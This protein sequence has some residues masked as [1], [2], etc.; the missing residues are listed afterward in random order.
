MGTTAEVLWLCVLGC[1][2][3]TAAEAEIP[4][5]KNSSHFQ[6]GLHQVGKCISGGYECIPHSKPWQVAL[7]YNG[8][9]YCSGVLVHQQWVL[10]A[11]HCWRRSYTVRLGLHRIQQW[12]EPGS[13][14]IEAN[15]SVQHPYYTP[16]WR[17]YDLMLVK[18]SKPVEL[19]ETIQPIHVA[20][21]CPET[22]TVC[23]ISGWGRLLDGQFPETLQCAYIPIV[24]EECCKAV[25]PKSYGDSMFCAGGLDHRDSCPDA[26]EQDELCDRMLIPGPVGTEISYTTGLGLHGLFEWDEPGSQMIEASVSV[27]HPDYVTPW[28]GHDLMLIKLNRPVVE[29]DTIRI[30]PITTQC[31]YP[32][33]LQC[34]FIPVLLEQYCRAL[35]DKHYHW[36]MFCAGAQG[37]KDTCPPWIAALF[38]DYE[39]FCS[40]VLVHPQWVLS[41]A[42]CWK[43]SYTIVLGLHR[44]FGWFKPGSQIIEASFSVQHPQY[45]TPRN[46]SDL[47]LIKLDRPAVESD[48]VRTI[49]I[50]SQC[51]TPGSRCWISGWG[52]LLD[53]TYPLELQCAFIPVVSEQYCRS[54][55]N[56]SYSDNMFCAGGEGYKDSCRV[57]DLDMEAEI[58]DGDEV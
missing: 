54:V 50:A 17:D 20:T 30:I 9:L 6:D 36:S 56:S 42:H 31:V 52:Q 25:Y 16:P 13:Q 28:K 5:K 44:V 38:D 18:L 11:A 32:E 51:P 4:P 15:F 19:S 55:L 43:P 35:Y 1:I 7:F 3:H 39:P 34:A 24:S 53:G 47:M 48:T 2:I 26:A 41:A 22:G 58:W 29:S 49:P 57:R 23:S 21:K 45:V 33:S 8:T 27:Q 46:G 10:S 37:Y 40:G 12:D 14:M